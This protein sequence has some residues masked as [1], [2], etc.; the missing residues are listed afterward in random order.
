[1]TLG[2]LSDPGDQE[3]TSRCVWSNFLQPSVARQTARQLEVPGTGWMNPKMLSSRKPVGSLG[4]PGV[5][6]VRYHKDSLF[7]SL[8]LKRLDPRCDACAIQTLPWATIVLALVLAA[9]VALF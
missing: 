7:S 8:E 5:S 9:H 4:S 1:M 2:A 3:S 6:G